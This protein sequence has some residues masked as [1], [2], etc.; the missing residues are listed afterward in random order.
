MPLA[1]LSLSQEGMRGDEGVPPV[2]VVVAEARE[3][4]RRGNY[5]AA[6]KLL[7]G[8]L[9]C[10][11]GNV[12]LIFELAETY[13]AQGYINQAHTVVNGYELPEDNIFGDLLRMLG[14]FLAPM[15]SGRFTESIEQ[16]DGI[17]SRHSLPEP[18][19]VAF[20]HV[21]CVPNTPPPY[22]LTATG[23]YPVI[24]LQD[25]LFICSIPSFSRHGPDGSC[26]E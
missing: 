4:V 25:P 22:H 9:V 8:A 21:V 6:E 24:I 20:M 14:C 18:S 11:Y 23:Y 7:K 15:V 10:H 1:G 3:L 5:A 19:D 12:E 2:S 26:T 16:A 17:N 13:A